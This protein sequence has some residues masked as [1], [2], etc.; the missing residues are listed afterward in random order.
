[1]TQSDKDFIT[2]IQVSQLVTADPYT[3]DFYA[4]VLGSL[5]RNVS[6]TKQGQGHRISGRREHAM[7]RMAEQVYRIVEN[8][9]AREK[10][11]GQ[12]GTVCSLLTCNY[13][14]DSGLLG[15]NPLQGVLGKTSGRSYKAAPRQLLQVDS[16][17][18]TGSPTSSPR[19]AEA[20][21]Y[22]TTAVQGEGG[23]HFLDTAALRS[24]SDCAFYQ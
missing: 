6:G 2:R 19:L 5:K 11:K 17:A 8:A 10:E 13:H 7:N 1:M 18:T 24:V 15:V 22:K 4:Q 9:K 20:E 16:A 23:Q 14:I 21:L 3:E 12:N